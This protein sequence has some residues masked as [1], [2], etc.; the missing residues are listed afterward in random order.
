MYADNTLTPKEALRLCALGAVAERPM[1]YSDLAGFVRH[2]TSRIIG[3]SLD[4]MGTSIELLRYEGLV[5]AIEGSGMED[6]A[7]LALTDAGR[8]E[9]GSLLT[10]RLRPATD[11]SK[12]VIALKFRFLHLLDAAERANQ[13]DLLI[14]SCETELNRLLDLRQTVAEGGHHLLEWLDH[15]IG[16]LENRLEWLEEFRERL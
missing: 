5:E 4:L 1:R 14:E 2:L 6:D 9:M 12:L 13:S 15:D 7:L 3:P 11:L 10:A 16:Q 8:R